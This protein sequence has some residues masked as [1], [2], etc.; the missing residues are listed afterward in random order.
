VGSTPDQTQVEALF[1]D[2]HTG[3]ALRREGETL[4]NEQ[5]V[6]WAIR[7]GIYDFKQPL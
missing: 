1:A 7:D 2:P 4:V 3:G 6:R 5:G